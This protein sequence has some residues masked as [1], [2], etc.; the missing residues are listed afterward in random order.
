MQESTET[1]LEYL[2]RISPSTDLKIMI[3]TPLAALGIR[4]GF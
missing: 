1:D 3:L 4:R 2:E